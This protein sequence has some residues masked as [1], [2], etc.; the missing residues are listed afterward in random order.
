MSF[1]PSIGSHS[2]KA[3]FVGTKTMASSPSASVMLQVNGIRPTTST[4]EL[5]GAPG[6][7][8]LETTVNATGSVMPTGTVAYLDTSNNNALLATAELGK[9]IVEPMSLFNPPSI[10]NPCAAESVAFADFN[11]DGFLDMACATGGQSVVVLLGNGD[12]TFSTQIVVPTTVMEGYYSAAIATADFNGDGIP[13][14]AVSGDGSGNVFVL[15]GNG[16]GTFTPVPGSATASDYVSAMAVGDFN[17]DGIPDL[18]VVNSINQNLTILLGNGDGTFT[19]SA[20]SPGTGSDP[21]NIAADDLNGDGKLDL[22][23]GG[24]PIT[25]LLGNGDGTFAPVAQPGTGS[26]GGNVAMGDFNGDGKLDVAVGNSGLTVWLGNGDGTF[27]A[28]PA[29]TIGA[30]LPYLVAVGDFNGDGIPDLAATNAGTYPSPETGTLAVLLGKGDGT[31][32]TAAMTNVGVDYANFLGTGNFNGDGKSDLVAYGYSLLIPQ[33][34]QKVVI[35]PDSISPIGSGTHQVVAVY[36]GDAKNAGS[37]SAVVSMVG[38]RLEPAVT[39]VPSSSAVGLG[40]LE[41]LTATVTGRPFTPGGTAVMPTGSIA[42]YSGASL[43]GSGALSSS[44]VATLATTT[45]PL[46]AFSFTAVYQGDTNYNTEISNPAAVTVTKRNPTATLTP[47]ATSITEGQTVKFTV[48]VSGSTPKPGGRVSFRDNDWEFG[49]ASLNGGVAQ[50]STSSLAVG[51]HSISAL[52]EGNSTYQRVTS[53]RVTVT[54]NSPSAVKL[55]VSPTETTAGKVAILKATVTGGTG[56]PTGTVKFYDGSNMLG[57]GALEDGAANYSTSALTA[58]SHSITAVYSGDAKDSPATSSPVGLTVAKATPAVALS[59]SASAV[60][61]GKQ[62]TLAASVKGNGPKPTG[63][64]T[65]YSGK[66]SLGAA[67]LDSG[68]KASVAT[69]KLAPGKNNVTAIYH[70]DMNNAAES[71]AVVSIAVDLN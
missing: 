47:S 53:N 9:G 48:S 19:A 65:F 58:G 15:L 54:V 41:T 42:F 67:D 60:V 29:S 24:T 2:Y 63:K 4:I 59:A 55:E 23:V 30:A 32:T 35:S 3:V 51:S 70:G 27:K 46:G 13:D 22:V 17:G 38:E 62:V 25:V 11:G 18:A 33:Q 12:G 64:V 40:L 45:L 37:T 36:S 71:S 21:G 6:D 44:G 66:T 20:S 34:L 57:S 49:T 68:G 1:T 50:L 16:D 10:Y 14:L 26:T 8:T 5:T 39:L 56:Q 61:A 7:Y 52:Y 28:A 69:E 43:M 31:F